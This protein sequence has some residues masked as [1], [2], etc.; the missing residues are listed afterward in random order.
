M[1]YRRKTY[2]KRSFRT[3]RRFPRFKR[4]TR[5]IRQKSRFNI[6]QKYPLLSRKGNRLNYVW[7]DKRMFTD[8]DEQIQPG[9]FYKKFNIFNSLYNIENAAEGLSFLNPPGYCSDEVSATINRYRYWRIKSLKVYITNIVI[10]SDLAAQAVTGTN[11]RTKIGIVYHYDD[12]TLPTLSNDNPYIKWHYLPLKKPIKI[13][14][15]ANMKGWFDQL[16]YSDQETIGTGLQTI[17]QGHSYNGLKTVSGLSWEL[18]NQQTPGKAVFLEGIIPKINSLHA[19]AYVPQTGN[20]N[21]VSST[22]C[23]N[24]TNSRMPKL[25]FC[26]LPDFKPADTTKFTLEYQMFQ[27]VSL[28]FKE[29]TEVWK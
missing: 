29:N 25:Y 14:W 22:Y 27:Y 18:S 21:F 4:R 26:F 17:V 3:R 9:T 16:S 19:P 12:A 15:R 13:Q 11:G 24:I 23:P 8:P 10:T 28:Q 1:V 6:F 2:K 20:V 5:K 7:A